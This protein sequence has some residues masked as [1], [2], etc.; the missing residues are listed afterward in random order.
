VKKNLQ[1]KNSIHKNYLKK[2]FNKKLSMLFNK[3]TNEIIDNIDL[4]R[5]S[6]NV[7]SDDFKFNFNL[8]DIKKFKKF[9][10]IVIIGMGGSI[11]GTEAIYNCFKKKIKKKFIFLIILILKKFYILKKKKIPV[12]LFF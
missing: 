7:L 3:Y 6:Y 10:T 4:P 12:K 5:E 2:N 8:K 1:I 11:L 9:K